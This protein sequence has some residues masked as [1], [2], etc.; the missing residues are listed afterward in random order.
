[1][2]DQGVPKTW[3][4]NFHISMLR[5][6]DEEIAR[7]NKRLNEAYARIRELEGGDDQGVSE[8]NEVDSG[9]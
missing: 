5:E 4:C 1:M 7:L 2:T 6:K 9:R 3:Q 8:E